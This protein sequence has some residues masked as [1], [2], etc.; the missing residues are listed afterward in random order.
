MKNIGVSI[1]LLESLGF[2]INRNKSILKSY[3]RIEF[4]E[5][6]YDSRNLPLE[7]SEEK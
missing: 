3:Q 6:I 2:I 7:L 4:L 1:N 5:I